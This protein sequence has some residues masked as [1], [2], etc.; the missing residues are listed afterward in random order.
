MLGELTARWQILAWV[1]IAAVAIILAIVWWRGRPSQPPAVTRRSH[2]LDE[3]ER[4]LLER[5]RAATGDELTVWPRVHAADVL[6]PRAEASSRRQR[7]A[8]RL[9]AQQSFDLL[10]CSSGDL[11]P[12]AVIRLAR[13]HRRNGGDPSELCSAAGLALF[14]LDPDADNDIAHLR[15]RLQWHIAEPSQGGFVATGEA[16]RTEPVIDLPPD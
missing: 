16:G 11:R 15:E 4:A 8:R 2:L 13:A 1:A 10:I 12:L 7:Q 3:S 5:L 9:L 14:N 6:E